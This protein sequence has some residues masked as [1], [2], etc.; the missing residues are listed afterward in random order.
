MEPRLEKAVAPMAKAGEWAIANPDEN[1]MVGH[2]VFD[3]TGPDGID[4]TLS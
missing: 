1:I 3:N 2:Y 4:N